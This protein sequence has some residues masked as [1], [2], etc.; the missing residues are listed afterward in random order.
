MLLKHIARFSM[1]LISFHLKFDVSS[2]IKMKEKWDIPKFFT[3]INNSLN[4]VW[5]HYGINGIEGGKLNLMIFLRKLNSNHWGC[6]CFNLCTSLF[7]HKWFIAF[8][9][10]IACHIWYIRNNYGGYNVKID[11]DVDIL[12]FK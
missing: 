1:S 4:W 3:I 11:N 9:S 6:W 5:C 7:K 8:N 12:Y 10:W 2:K